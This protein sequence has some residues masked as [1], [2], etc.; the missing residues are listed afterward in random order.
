[1]ERGGGGVDEITPKAETRRTVV[2]TKGSSIPSGK[3]QLERSSDELLA[4]LRPLI[5][6]A[7]AG[8]EEAS[9]AIRNIL[10]EEPNLAHTIVE[11]A[12]RKTERTLLERSSGDNVLLREGLALGLQQKREEIAGPNP[13]SLEVLLAER[14]VICRLQLEQ[15]EVDYASRLGKLTISQ[16]EYHQRRVDRLH[17]R[18]LSAIRELAQV[19]K[20]LKPHVAQ[21]NVAEKQVN[22]S[23]ERLKPNSYDPFRNAAEGCRGT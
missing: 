8:D 2:S 23:S 22:L 12:A 20:L 6:R 7:Q 19:R 1:V 10:E 9:F 13:S 4:E 21:I 11:V 14:I 5:G 3:E 17:K 15:A 18:Y 16:D